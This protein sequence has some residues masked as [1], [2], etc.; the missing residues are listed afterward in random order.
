M[1]LKTFLT[2]HETGLYVICAPES[3]VEADGITA[4]HVRQ[5]LRT[6]A[7][8]FRYVVVDTAP[9]L[10]D[11]TLAAMDET[12]DLVMMSS[13]DVPGLRGLRKEVDTVRELGLLQQR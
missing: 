2:L 11:H 13:M 12:T 8:E 5:L 1:V 4:D 7:T 9:G 3:P 6:L 10:S